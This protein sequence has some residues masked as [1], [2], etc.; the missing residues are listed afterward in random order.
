LIQGKKS[1]FKIT[2]NFYRKKKNMKAINLND[3][4]HAKN[5]S[6]HFDLRLGLITVAAAALTGRLFQRLAGWCQCLRPGPDH[7]QRIHQQIEL[8]LFY[9]Y[10]YYFL[11]N[12]EK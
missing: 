4:S 2:G 1:F 9:H 8:L 10:T 5:K 7:C 11:K 12:N 6:I 3:I